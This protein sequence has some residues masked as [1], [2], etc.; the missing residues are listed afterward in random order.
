MDKWFR[1][2]W[3]VLVTVFSVAVIFCL[4]APLCPCAT[5]GDPVPTT[6]YY[7]WTRCATMY[8]YW[9]RCATMYYYYVLL[10]GR[11]AGWRVVGNAL[12]AVHVRV[13]F[14]CVTDFPGNFRKPFFFERHRF[15]NEFPETW[16]RAKSEGTTR[17][18]LAVLF[19]IRIIYC[20]LYNT[21]DVLCNLGP[22][23]VALARGWMD[24]W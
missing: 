19:I 23:S 14:S 4:L 17:R 7:Y 15:P 13:K 6:M 2:F 1:F 5:L 18:E 20:I 21:C 9:T 24:A 8:Y 11:G 12:R 10:D 3:T 22:F 16:T